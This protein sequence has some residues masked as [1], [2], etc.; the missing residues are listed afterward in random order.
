MQH[1]NQFSIVQQHV[2]YLKSIYNI[3]FPGIRV[4]VLPL[5]FLPRVEHFKWFVHFP[6]FV[7]DL[8]QSL[9]PT[10]DNKL[11]RCWCNIYTEIEEP[12]CVWE[13]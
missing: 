4:A 7:I 3:F 6:E 10:E 13:F 12:I 5:G 11:S 1:T 2:T 9:I 8:T